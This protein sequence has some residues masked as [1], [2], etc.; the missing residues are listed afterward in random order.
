LAGCQFLLARSARRTDILV[1]KENSMALRRQPADV[2]RELLDNFDH[3]L[4]V[5]EHL[6]AVL[7][8]RLWHAAPPGGDG[9]SI[10]AIVAHMQSIRRTFAKMGGADPA[11]A[12]LDRSSSTP[13]DA[14]RALQESREALMQLFGTALAEGRPRVKGMPRRTVNMMLYVLQHDAHHRGQISMLARELGHRLS[15]EDVMRLWGWKKL[16]ANP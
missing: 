6:I 7:P 15:S 12:S 13:A 1:A 9:R 10:S 16:A 4:H 11:L 14:R 8:G 2:E 3:G 5:S